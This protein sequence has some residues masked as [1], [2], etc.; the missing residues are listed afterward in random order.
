MGQPDLIAAPS[1]FVP[2]TGEAHWE[3]LI[4]ARAVENLAHV[5]AAAQA[6]E[7]PGGR[8]THGDTMIAYP[9]GQVLARA[10]SDGN[11]CVIAVVDADARQQRRRQL[12][13]LQNR[14]YQ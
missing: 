5:L 6:G 8:K 14:R 10:Q 1:A 7:H 12:P 9:W 11:E 13:A 3:L 2:K 4:R